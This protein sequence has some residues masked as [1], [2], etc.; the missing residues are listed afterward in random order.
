MDASI[1][2]ALAEL[3]SE[4]TVKVKPTPLSPK[5][6]SRDVIRHLRIVTPKQGRADATIPISKKSELL[7]C[8]ETS[9]RGLLY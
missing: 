5:S 1:L 4:N 9:I 2:N 6:V 8:D 3:I 7:L